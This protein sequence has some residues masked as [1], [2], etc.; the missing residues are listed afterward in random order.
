MYCDIT[1]EEL[2]LMVEGIRGHTS[3]ENLDLHGNRI[4]NT[5]CLALTT[6]LKDSNCN[7]RTLDLG[8]NRVNMNGA[9][10]IVNSLS[11]NKRLRHLYLG[12]KTQ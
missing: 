6:L 1:D 9:I 4:G 5:R 3:L 10:A 12:Y 7:I 8:R 11:K 2:L